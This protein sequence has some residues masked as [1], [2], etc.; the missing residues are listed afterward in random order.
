M[1][2]HHLLAALLAIALLVGASY[3]AGLTDKVI[4]RP[5]DNM[6]LG[7]T[8]EASSAASPAGGKY[9]V[10]M[11]ADNDGTTG[12]ASANAALPQWVKVTFPEPRQL[13]TLVLIERDMPSLYAHWKTVQVEFSEGDPEIGRASCRERV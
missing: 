12:W 4:C 2:Y 6:V 11:L 8:V 10:E 13:D 3:A 5:D 7:A 1:R 9:A